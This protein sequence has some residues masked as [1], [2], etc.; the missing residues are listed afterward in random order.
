MGT[1]IFFLQQDFNN[2]NYKINLVADLDI[3]C[4]LTS[5]NPTSCNYC[6]ISDAKVVL[7]QDV[8]ISTLG[9]HVVKNFKPNSVQLNYLAIYISFLTA[10]QSSEDLSSFISYF[11]L[12]VFHFLSSYCSLI[13]VYPFQFSTF[14]LL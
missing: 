14:G 6:V 7:G 11:T 1:A 13:H 2:E 9:C 5:D 8:I 12:H 4:T 3:L 10:R